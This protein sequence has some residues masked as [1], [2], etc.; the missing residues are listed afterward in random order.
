MKKK[1]KR[2]PSKLSSVGQQNEVGE[3]RQKIKYRSTQDC[4]K[5]EN[6]HNL[7][8]WL[9]KKDRPEF[10]QMI[11]IM[12]RAGKDVSLRAL[13]QNFPHFKSVFNI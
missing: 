6:K 8:Q 7:V 9:I 13:I 12:L 11:A 4:P 2:Q 10:E 3:E 1:L 5:F